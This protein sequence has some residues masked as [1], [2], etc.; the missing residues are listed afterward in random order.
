MKRFIGIFLAIVIGLVFIACPT[1]NGGNGNNGNTDDPPFVPP[2]TNEKQPGKFSATVLSDTMG[3]NARSVSLG[4]Y[5]IANSKSIFFIL[6]NVGDFPI[7]NITLTPGKLIAEGETFVTITDGG[8]VASPSGITVLET[9][10]N[11][12]VET[13][14]EVNIN[15]G[16]VVGLISQ[17]YIQKVDFAGATLRIAG[18]T[19]DDEDSILDISLDVD[20]ET[21]IKVASFEVQYSTDGGA[22]YVKA[23]Y[24]YPKNSLGENG[25]FSRFIVPSAGLNHVRIY[26]S[27]NTPLKYAIM[28]TDQSPIWVY[29]AQWKTLGVGS[30]SD[31]LTK[32]PS[33]AEERRRFAIDTIGV[34]FDNAGITSLVYIPDSSI[35]YDN[36]YY[37]SISNRFI[38]VGL[39]DAD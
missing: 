3:S 2:V 4:T 25:Q 11:T 5:D 36:A 6:R 22:T 24:G 10:G 35:I 18:K 30:R 39:P 19:T 17:Q 9:S 37:G 21:H 38:D 1:G 15:H 23:E 26:N 34:A 8:I 31:I 7:T 13:V 12:T 33:I 16:N 32:T 28:G 27:G 20:I 14:I 29:Q